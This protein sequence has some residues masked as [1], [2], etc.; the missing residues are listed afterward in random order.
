M[1]RWSA[2]T[3]VDDFVRDASKGWHEFVIEIEGGDRL[4]VPGAVRSRTPPASCGGDCAPWWSRSS[5]TASSRPSA[6]CWPWAALRD[7]AA[8]RAPPG[9]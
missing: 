3:E 7:W 2:A 9:S 4:P 1:E 5:G 8:G 6:T